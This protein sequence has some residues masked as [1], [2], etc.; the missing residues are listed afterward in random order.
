MSLL[1]V[2][3]FFFMQKTAYEMRI[4]DWSSDV[5]SSDLLDV[6]RVIAIPKTREVAGRMDALVGADAHGGPGDPREHRVVASG[7]RLLDQG[8]GELSGDVEMALQVCCGPSL[9]RVD[10]DGRIGCSAAHGTHA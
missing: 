9:V 7:E 5:C 10:D 8:D 1:F 4:S 2:L 6:D 3:V